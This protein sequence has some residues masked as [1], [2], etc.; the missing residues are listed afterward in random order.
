MVDFL[1][2]ANIS[3]EVIS[4]MKEEY[5]DS[6]LFDLSCNEDDCLKI[7]NYL[8]E[9]GISNI[10]DLLLYEIEVFKLKFNDLV[11]KLSKFN[12]PLFVNII[13][14]EYVSIEN[15]FRVD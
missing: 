1:K 14:E 13:N 5:S 6:T 2:K 12:I 10:D 7:I 8:K 3:D 9:L 11:K 15:L 4:K